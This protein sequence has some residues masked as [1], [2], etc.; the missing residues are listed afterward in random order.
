[1]LVLKHGDKTKVLAAESTLIPLLKAE[2]WKVDGEPDDV[3]EDVS[4]LRAQAEALGLKPHH[5]LGAEK[6]KELI[7]AAKKEAE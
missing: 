3:S 6:L 2:G 4:G 7:E 1:M 5:K